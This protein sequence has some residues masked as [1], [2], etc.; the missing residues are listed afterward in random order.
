MQVKVTPDQK[1]AQRFHSAMRDIQRISGM[2]FETV[3]KH[4]LGAMLK[5]AVRGTKK[6]SA[7]SIKKNWDKQPGAQYGFEYAGPESRSGKTYTAADIARASKRA[8]Q[9]RAAGKNGKLVYYFSASNQAKAY[10]SWLW[11]EMQK[12]RA[13]SLA[14]RTQSRGLAASMFVRIG[15]KL[16]IP[17]DAPGYVKNAKHHKRGQMSELV[18]VVSSGSGNKYE[19]GFV[20]NLTHLNRWSQAGTAF[21]RALN[22]R[23]KYFSKAVELKAAGTIKKVLDR[24]PGLASMGGSARVRQAQP[25]PSAAGTSGSAPSSASRSTSTGRRGGV[26]EMRTSASGR[27][28]KKYL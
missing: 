3:M 17:V 11:R 15:E 8:A 5:S 14:N 2:D 21:R 13:T 6:A 25:Q 27:Q 20:N 12:N 10:P 22:A 7:N 18:E 4:E 28:Y 24:Y 26:F 19:V 1:A 16:G 9:R 23:A